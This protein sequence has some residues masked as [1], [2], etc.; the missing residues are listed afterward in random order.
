MKKTEIVKIFIK[1]YGYGLPEAI[2]KYKYLTAWG[3]IEITEQDI[4]K[5]IKQGG[6]S[7]D[8]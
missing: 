7:Y 6:V 8:F 4:E 1:K 3:E 2:E 5:Y